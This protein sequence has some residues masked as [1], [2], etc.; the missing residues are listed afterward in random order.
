MNPPTIAEPK[1]KIDAALLERVADRIGTGVP[2]S[3][4]LAGESVS[5]AE[6]QEHLRRN[7]ELAGLEG[8]ARRKFFQNLVKML[9]DAKDPTASCRWLLKRLYPEV[10]INQPPGAAGNN[11]SVAVNVTTT[12]AGMSED[13]LKAFREE[14]ATY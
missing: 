10:M 7:P 12:I 11:N 8:M 14:A 1:S 6:Y 9:L 13:E 3:L 2:L 5:C 4:A